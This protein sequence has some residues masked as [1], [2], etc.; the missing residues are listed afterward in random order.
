MDVRVVPAAFL[1][2]LISL[3][4]AGSNGE[5]HQPSSLTPPEDL[6]IEFSER[7]GVA[8][9][10][11]G[12]TINSSG[13]VTE[14]SGVGPDRKEL[15]RPRLTSGALQGIWDMATK[16]RVFDQDEMFGNGNPSRRLV[17]TA[18]GRRYSYAWT[19]PVGELSLSGSLNSFFDYC[20]A[21]I[22]K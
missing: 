14:W 4:C 6:K 9:Q 8:G 12:Y 13:T 3:S 5:Y 7:V 20:V 21:A 2:I 10:W 1:A 19:P 18:R 17:V 22:K 15:A 11:S 16:S